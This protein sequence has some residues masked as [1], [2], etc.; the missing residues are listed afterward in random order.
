MQQTIG[1]ICAIMLCS[2]MLTGCFISRAP[3]IAENAGVLPIDGEAWIGAD[4][5]RQSFPE[6]DG[7]RISGDD[8]PQAPVRFA[9]LIAINGA[10]YFI[11]EVPTGEGEGSWFYGIARRT[12]IDGVAGPVIQLA[13]LDCEKLPADIH[14]QMRDAG[15]LVSEDESEVCTPPDLEA[16]RSLFREQLTQEMLESDEW[17]EEQSS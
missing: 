13:L 4:E 8:A 12:A 9:P 1:R 11:T 2:L 17:W 10:Q 3:L 7:Y 14:L 15:W 6:G 5:F 16:L